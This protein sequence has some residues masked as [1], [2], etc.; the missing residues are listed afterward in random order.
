MTIPMCRKAERKIGLFPV[1]RGI[2]AGHSDPGVSPRLI[3]LLFGGIPNSP[4]VL[5]R[6]YC[7]VSLSRKITEVIASP[8]FPVS[9]VI[10]LVKVCEAK[11][12]RSEKVCRAD[13]ITHTARTLLRSREQPRRR[14]VHSRAPRAG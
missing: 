9:P 14:V 3:L 4:A 2:L 13:T 5:Q 11:G 1:E 10:R 6:S 7:V 12:L 8:A